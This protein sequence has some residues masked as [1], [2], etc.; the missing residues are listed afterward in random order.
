MQFVIIFGDVLTNIFYLMPLPHMIN[1]MHKRT[2]LN[3]TPYFYS[4]LFTNSLTWTIYSFMLNDIYMISSILLGFVLSFFYMQ[5]SC[6]SHDIVIC[7][8]IANGILIAVTAY[9]FLRWTTLM[10]IQFYGIVA[11]VAEVTLLIIPLIYVLKGNPI[12]LWIACLTVVNSVIWL[13]Y[14]ILTRDVYVALPNVLT[15]MSGFIQLGVWFYR[16]YRVALS[17]APQV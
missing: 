14:G 1:V 3:I 11:N 2:E 6:T 9:V 4:A 15:L 10:L 12:V 7:N 13:M 16:R 8:S 5:V 17:A